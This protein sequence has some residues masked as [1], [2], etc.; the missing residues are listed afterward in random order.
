MGFLKDQRNDV[1]DK[2]RDQYLNHTE[3]LRAIQVS[4]A[5][6]ATKFLWATNGGAAVAL[7]AFMGSSQPIR[8]SPYVHVSLFAFFTGLVALVVVRAIN[9]HNTTQLLGGW[10]RETDKALNSEIDAA[11][12]G[13][14]LQQQINRLPW[15]APLFGYLSFGCFVFG[16]LWGACH[17]SQ[18]L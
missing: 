3:V 5:D 16:V 4:A 2:V 12:P 18:I 15:V 17:L 7:L 11:A 1:V 8:H 14:W 9:Y 10:I 6:E 13:Q